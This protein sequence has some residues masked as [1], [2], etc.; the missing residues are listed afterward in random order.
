M[1]ICNWLIYFNCWKLYSCVYCSIFIPLLIHTTLSVSDCLLFDSATTNIHKQIHWRSLRRWIPPVE[2]H[3]PLGAGVWKCVCAVCISWWLG[4]LRATD[5]GVWGMFNILQYLVL[6][7]SRSPLLSL[8]WNKTRGCMFRREIIHVVNAEGWYSHFF[9]PCLL[10]ILKDPG[11]SQLS[12]I[13]YIL[14]SVTYSKMQK[15][16][17]SEG[18]LLFSHQT[19]WL[20]FSCLFNY[21]IRLCPTLHCSMQGKRAECTLPY[22]LPYLFF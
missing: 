22:F 1:D 4:M 18:G 14:C 11:R 21:G 6:P 3:C 13:V 12:P 20:L 16:E 2:M 9:P 19:L 10:L 8:C 5:N 7:V 17:R 15:K